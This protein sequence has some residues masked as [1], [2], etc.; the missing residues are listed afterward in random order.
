MRTGC[1]RCKSTGLIAVKH[2]LT[3]ITDS[4][5]EIANAYRDEP[6][7]A[8]GVAGGAHALKIKSSEGDKGAEF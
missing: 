3:Y 1:R 2:G 6:C 8:C 5:D 7:P 4:D